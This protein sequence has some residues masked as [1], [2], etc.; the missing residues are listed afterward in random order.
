VVGDIRLKA[1]RDAQQLIEY[2]SI[3]GQKR[4]LSRQQLRRLVTDAAGLTTTIRPGISADNADAMTYGTLK[5]WQIQQ[6]RQA[7]ARLIVAPAR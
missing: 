4:D 3:R 5:D 7:I 6:L 2:L 1:F